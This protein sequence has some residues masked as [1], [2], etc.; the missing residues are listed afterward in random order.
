MVDNRLVGGVLVPLSPTEQ[1]ERDA[2]V[3]AAEAQKIINADPDV[4]AEK[5]IVEEFEANPKRR[6]LFKILFDL[7]ND[8]R[9]LEGKA[10]ISP[11]TAREQFRLLVKSLQ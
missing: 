9:V 10:T 2:E 11:A 7:I 4:I 3:A 6:A 1:S 8:V 5:D